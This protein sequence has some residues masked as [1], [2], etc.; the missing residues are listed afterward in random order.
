MGIIKALSEETH[1]V[2]V[3]IAG[4]GTAGCIVAS[5]LADAAPGLS[6]LL[7]EHGPDS[8]GNPLVRHP[9]LWRANLAP[10]SGTNIYYVAKEE[11]QLSGR[12]I[13]VATGGI[14]GGG[15][16]INLS[17]YTRPQAV[18]YDAWNMPGW[19]AQ[20]LL[21][22]INKS[23]TYHGE[24]KI[25]HHGQHGPIQISSGPFC[26]KEAE[27]DFISAVA[28]VG[29]PEVRDLQ[30]LHTSKGVSHC[31][32]YVSADGRRQDV[33]HTYIHPRLQDGKHDNLHVLV[34]SQ[35]T[36]VLFDD[37][38]KRAT[39]VEY[40][41]N[42]A[43][44]KDAS[45]QGTREIKARKLVVLSCGALGNP[46]I[47]ERSGV[48]HPEVL[49]RAGV[50]VI[51]SVTGVGQGYQDHQV[52]SYHYKSSIPKEDTSDAGFA[53]FPAGLERLLQSNDKTLG[54]NGFDASSKIRPSEAE[55]NAL[56]PEF[57]R[58]W[59]RDFKNVPQKPLSSMI[60]STGF[61]GDP[62]IV[63]QGSYFSLGLYNAYPYSRGHVHITGPRP[64]DPADFETGFLADDD[65]LDLK[66]H[67]WAY[68]KQR[69][70]ARRMG[71]CLGEAEGQTP[72]FASD[73]KAA[74]AEPALAGDEH[75]M[76]YSADDDAAIGDWV[77]ENITTCWHG[78]GTCKMA[79]T[80][81]EGVVDEK[82]N[83]HGLQGLKVADLS[84][85][86]GNVSSNTH[87]TALM[88]GEKAA[89]IIIQDV[90]QP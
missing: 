18:D 20:D 55:V 50:P 51:A 39:G 24:G 52:I 47:L 40:R 5:R 85:A 12:G 36:K 77:R 67:I 23:E 37:V 82:L 17:I 80:G 69:E 79:P 33:A 25:E 46:G 43:I 26:Q 13:P 22:F 1:E 73:S 74:V 54:W 64:D 62:R 75:W 48:G 41:A 61:A 86:P 56:G 83:V 2:D 45:Q 21:P 34:E 72:R 30:D 9:L 84:I 81:D 90:V 53:D 16:S 6:I 42:P 38:M 89:D 60:M 49:E 31:L 88:I 76:K 63:P 58:A 7:I 8:A 65:Q 4:G 28:R 15:S 57:R 44:Q 3:I 66:M 87:N 71:I 59:E 29:Y 35:V 27:R 78:L 14:L 19:S 68:K 11:S 70:V 10:Q 32:K